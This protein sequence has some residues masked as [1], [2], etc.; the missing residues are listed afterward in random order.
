MRPQRVGGSYS[1]LNEAGFSN[2]LNVV[3]YRKGSDRIANNSFT[4]LMMI[5]S[6]IRTSETF[7]PT[8][9]VSNKSEGTASLAKRLSS[10]KKNDDAPVHKSKAAVPIIS[11]ANVR[12]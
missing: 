5:N 9:F 3:G 6:I 10:K 11:K 1:F 12:V 8:K 7:K 4:K 2:N